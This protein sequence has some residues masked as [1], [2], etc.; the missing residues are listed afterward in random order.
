[1][2]SKS[3]SKRQRTTKASIKKA[4]EKKA[5]TKPLPLQA[6]LSLKTPSGYGSLTKYSELISTPDLVLECSIPVI[7]SRELSLV[8]EHLE[9]TS[10]ATARTGRTSR[11]I[12]TLAR[13]FRESSLLDPVIYL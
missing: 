13:N 2:N 6:T 9:R 1:M 5:S 4:L 3:S 8:V 7:A 12:A 11:N 10:L